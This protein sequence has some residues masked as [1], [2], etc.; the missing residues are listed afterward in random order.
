MYL[1]HQLF[2]GYACHLRHSILPQTLLKPLPCIAA[3]AGARAH[4]T[5]TASPLHSSCFAD[6]VLN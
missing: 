2:Q 4:T 1:Q 3:V 5:S 6:P